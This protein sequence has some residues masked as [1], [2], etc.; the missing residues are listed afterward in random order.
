MRSKEF[1]EKK[2]AILGFGVEGRETVEWLLKKG[3]TV[4]VFDE[5]DESEFDTEYISFLKKDGVTFTFG[6]FGALELFDIIVRSPGVRP[7]IKTLHIASDLG[8]PITT[9]TSIFLSEA[10]GITVGIT[11][12]KG[13]G[14]T[15]ALLYQ[16]L[17]TADK[18][19]Y[20]G[21]NIGVPALS[22]LHKLKND[23]VS[24][25]E[26]SS[27]QL[28]D[29]ER[30]PHIAMVLMVTQD[31]L[32]YHASK[33]EYVMAKMGITRHQTEKDIT[34]YNAEYPASVA[35]ADRSHGTRYAVSIKGKEGMSCYLEGETVMLA[36]NGKAIPVIKTSE[37]LLPGRHNLENVCAAVLTAA[38]L[39]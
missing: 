9:A 29:V 25:L 1:K 37:I 33:D 20:I 16:M 24:I 10:P 21:G 31:H 38:L 4:H 19:A 34:I 32:D 18:D 12:T 28:S 6:A 8:I 3:A 23:S 13:K 15:S 7:G 2:V 36:L 26:L 22:F 35:I 5:K 30:S 11:G 14:T 17:R 39:N 27:F